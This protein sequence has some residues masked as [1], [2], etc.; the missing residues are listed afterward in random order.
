[1]ISLIIVRTEKQ[2]HSVQCGY[3][4]QIFHIL[5][6]EITLYSPTLAPILAS[7]AISAAK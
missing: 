3:H 5:S 2:Q 7:K 1:M 4:Q 6:R